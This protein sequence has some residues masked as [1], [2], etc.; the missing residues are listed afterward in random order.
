M[1]A[2]ALLTA[3]LVVAATAVAGR[4]D[5]L[6]L[7]GGRIY[8]ANPEQP[9]AE[10]LAIDDGVITYVGDAAGV[11]AHI[12]G[13]TRIVNLRRGMALPG[14]HDVHVHPLEAGSESFSCVLRTRGTVRSWLRKVRR[15]TRR[16]DLTGEWLVGAGFSVST[17]IADG[18]DPAR[19]LDEVSRGRPVVLMDDTSHA[20]WANTRALELMGY[21]R[22]TE[23]GSGGHI[24]RRPDGTPNGLLFDTASDEVFHRA[25]GSPSQALR[26]AD[27]RGLLWSLRQIRKRGITS[28]CNARL[29]WKR[30]YLDAWRRARAEGELTA[31]TALA[32]W[33]YP[34]ELDDDTQLE[35]LTQMFDDDDPMLRIDHAKLY[36]DGIS[37]N[38]TAAML[39]P[40]EVDLGLGLSSATGLLYFEPDRLAHHLATLER[41]GFHLLIHA[42]GDRGVRTA[43]DS[44]E[45]AA[46]LNGDLGRDR[47]HRLTHVE[48]VHPDD[49]PRFAEL[50]VIA[51]AQVACECS[52]SGREDEAERELVG[53]ARIRDRVP[54]RDLAAAGAR[55]TLSSD[56]DVAD[57]SPFV[58]IENALR[59]GEQQ[60]DDLPTVL[61]AY[62][63][64]AAFALGQEDRVGTLEVGKRGDVTV[65]DR[66]LFR[67]ATRHIGTTKVNATIV[68]GEIVYRR[69][70][71]RRR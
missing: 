28:I 54:L 30:G 40:Y 53:E 16:Q 61:D 70:K 2:R 17:L 9:F 32:L 36:A 12:D 1:R 31:R 64:D 63:R 46:V 22:E 29:Y 24:G 39:A 21:D 6:V 68:D 58:G 48:Y 57:L 44:L 18:R 23:A 13:G 52:I 35:L 67:I 15:C 3:L 69:P 33:V 27:Y 60:L 51:D 62:T 66:D 5:D 8:T 55:I 4:A 42:I 71:R 38:T 34:E 50:D 43:L 59:R 65:I 19:A 10:A 56:W 47:R 25:L 20:G 7:R 49:L 11:E 26:D 41:A 45:A 37:I 14:L